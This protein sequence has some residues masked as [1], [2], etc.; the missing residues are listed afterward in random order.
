MAPDPKAPDGSEN[1]QPDGKQNGNPDPNVQA[2]QKKLTEKDR[3][4]KEAL[5]QIE[6]IKKTKDEK[7]DETK[8]EIQK[9]TETVAALTGQIGDINAE[10]K[11]AKLAEKYPDILPEFLLG[12]SDEEVELI[13]EKQRQ[14]IMENYDEK[15]SAHAPT[16][17]SRGDVDKAIE[18]IKD[19]KTIR[20]DA[21]MMK[22]RE[23]KMI[24]EKI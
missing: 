5:E 16:Y 15:P 24:R 4:L 3:L 23:L 13:V 21:K 12:K 18:K 20:T 6:E 10:T 11:K 1:G 7:N 9:L 14:K 8:S 17:S 22:I 2:L 19:D